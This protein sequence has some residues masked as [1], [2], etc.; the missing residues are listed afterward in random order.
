M[1][2]HQEVMHDFYLEEGSMIGMEIGGDEYAML[3]P[4]CAPSYFLYKPEL[5]KSELCHNAK[6][7]LCQKCQEPEC[8][9]SGRPSEVNPE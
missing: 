7:E 1:S 8:E 9:L 4:H 6:T 3:C 2:E 5:K